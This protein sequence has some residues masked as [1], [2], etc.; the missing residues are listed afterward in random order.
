MAK[1]LLFGGRISF[2]GMNFFKHFL[3]LCVTFDVAVLF[4]FI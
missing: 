4:L 3:G 2:Y 1:K